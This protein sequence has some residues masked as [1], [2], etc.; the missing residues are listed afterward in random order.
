MNWVVGLGD[1]FL[2]FWGLGQANL[3]LGRAWGLP[4]S[5][6]GLGQGNLGFG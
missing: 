2:I 3:G 4:F 1:Y 5:F 6:W